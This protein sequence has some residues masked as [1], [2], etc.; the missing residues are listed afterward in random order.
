M[1][2]NGRVEIYRAK[3]GWRWRAIAANGELVSAP[4]EAYSKKGNAKRAGD[5]EARAR[6][7]RLV[8]A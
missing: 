5:R 8:G 1:K 4:G 2:R 7:F 6:G 3:D